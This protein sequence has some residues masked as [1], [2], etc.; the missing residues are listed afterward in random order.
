MWH[1]C[2]T[3]PVKWMNRSQDGGRVCCCQDYCVDTR[4]ELHGALWLARYWL[5]NAWRMYTQID[6]THDEMGATGKKV[7]DLFCVMNGW[8][9][10]KAET[11]DNMLCFLVFCSEPH[12]RF[13]AA[14]IVLAF[15][16]LHYLDLIY[17]D[18][19]P[20]NLLIDQ[21]GYISVSINMPTP[22][23]CGLTT[24]PVSVVKVYFEY[25]HYLEYLHYL[26]LIY[27][28]LKPGNHL[29][30]QEGYISVGTTNMPV[31]HHFLSVW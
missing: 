16:Y 20:E 25:I 4:Q 29:I 8:D 27:R 6:C 28:D 12:S 26:D 2:V 18:L 7:I 14:Q 11:S 19:K 9:L 24:P 22:F 17:R 31:T 23:Q 13:Y 21:E 3:W 1:R 10:R 15:E 30:D 5:R